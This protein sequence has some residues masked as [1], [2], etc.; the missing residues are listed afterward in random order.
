M[1]PLAAT[2]AKPSAPRISLRTAP[3]TPLPKRMAQPPP[4]PAAADPPPASSAP[5]APWPPL[6]MSTVAGLSTNPIRRFIDA[7]PIDPQHATQPHIPLSLGDP[8]VYGN[9]ALP[10]SLVEMVQASLACVGLAGRRRAAHPPPLPPTPSLTPPHTP[11]SP[12]AQLAKAQ[13][14]RAQRRQPRRAPR[15]GGLL[16]PGRPAHARA[17]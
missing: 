17:V 7:M 11:P 2:R 16:Q 12:A 9:F 5:P 14:L 8:T 3:P 6:P 4:P 10:P 1:F 15:R 13:W